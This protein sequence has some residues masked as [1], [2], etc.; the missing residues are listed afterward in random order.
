MTAREELELI[1]IDLKPGGI[2]WLPVPARRNPLT[3]KRT[4]AQRYAENLRRA[5]YR[6]GRRD[7]RFVCDV[8]RVGVFRRDFAP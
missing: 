2:R 3:G 1:L 8:V 6:I 4:D 7:L 5:A